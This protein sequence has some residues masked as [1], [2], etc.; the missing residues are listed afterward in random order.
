MSTW[1]NLAD[2]ERTEAAIIVEPTL[3]SDLKELMD[4]WTKAEGMIKAQHPEL[5][6][7]ELY[8]CT[9][10]TIEMALGIYKGE[11]S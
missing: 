7:Y 2:T 1:G 10:I 11:A 8:Q 3:K 6:G 4:A 5:D 9:R